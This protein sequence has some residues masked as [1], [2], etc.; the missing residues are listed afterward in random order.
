MK[1]KRHFKPEEFEVTLNNE[2]RDLLN[3]GLLG[4]LRREHELNT[5]TLPPSR[6]R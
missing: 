3:M 5:A 1:K 4:D 2:T 6:P